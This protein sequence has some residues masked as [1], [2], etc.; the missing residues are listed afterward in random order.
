M[1]VIGTRLTLIDRSVQTKNSTIH[2]LPVLSSG[3]GD[4][5]LL[6]VG[7]NVAVR[8]V[9]S[10]VSVSLLLEVSSILLCVGG[11][12]L[13]V[14][15]LVP[16]FTDNGRRLGVHILILGMSHGDKRANHKR[17]LSGTREEHKEEKEWI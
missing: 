9:T 13:A 1:N 16:L 5:A 2:I 12:E 15:A 3:V 4:S 11:S 17:L 10:A 14:S 7:V 6:A 8:S